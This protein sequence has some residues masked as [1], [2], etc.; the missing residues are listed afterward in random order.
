MTNE[1][2]VNLKLGDDLYVE[3]QSAEGEE[4]IT[5]TKYIERLIDQ[6]LKAAGDAEDDALDDVMQRIV[7]GVFKYI[8][9]MGDICEQ[10]PAEKI[11]NEYVVHMTPLIDEYLQLAYGLHPQRMK[12]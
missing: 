12:R 6:R 4:K 3:V 1:R 5:L 9:R 11:V 10:D 8:D 2:I 7:D